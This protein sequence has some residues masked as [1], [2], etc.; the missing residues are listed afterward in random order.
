MNQT[1]IWGKLNMD[2]AV[3]DEGGKLAGN[4]ASLLNEK[5]VDI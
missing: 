4:C 5:G 1:K 2:M 3:Q